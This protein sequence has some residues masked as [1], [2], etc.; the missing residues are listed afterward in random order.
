[1]PLGA[2]P[3]GGLASQIAW[4][5]RTFEGSIFTEDPIDLGGAT[6]F[7]ITK[8][9][10]EDFRGHPVSVQEVADLTESEA[11]DIGVAIFAVESGLAGII[12]AR[13]RLACLDYAFHAGWVPAIRALQTAVG[14]SVDGVCGPLTLKA[15][16]LQRIP[17]LTAQAICTTR[18]QKLLAFIRK[19]PSQAKFALGWWSRVNLI[20]QMTY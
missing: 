2:D 5:L 18:E 10:L 15:A 14:E 20:R 3:V 6:K 19:L 12:D 1:M 16:N 13:L 4:I 8:R 9:T 17:Q 7:G 11:I